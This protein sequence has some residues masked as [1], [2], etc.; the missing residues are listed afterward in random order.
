MQ[1]QLTAAEMA[2]LERVE[3]LLSPAELGG[4]CVLPVPVSVFLVG[5]Y[6]HGDTHR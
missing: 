2:D 5:G 3:E 1:L 4:V 6:E